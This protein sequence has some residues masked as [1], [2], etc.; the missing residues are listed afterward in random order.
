MKATYNKSEI[1]RRAW[2]LFKAQDIRTMEMWST[3]LKESWGIAKNSIEAIDINTIYEK[4]YQSVYHFVLGRVNH[5]ENAEEIANDVFIKAHKHRHNYNV[6]TAKV[7]TWLFSIAK[8]AVID[9]YRTNHADHYVKVS[10][11]VDDSGKEVYQFTDNSVDVVENNELAEQIMSAF[12]SLKPKYRRVAE[13]FFLNQK[14]YKEIA[15]ILDIPM[16]TVFGMISRCRAMLQDS[17]V[18][19]R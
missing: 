16:G 8:N 13:L 19:V 18:A 15:E 6:H 5:T 3:S 9:F 1:M 4:Y 11:F 10:D 2:K 7:S 12:T 17:L 14:Q